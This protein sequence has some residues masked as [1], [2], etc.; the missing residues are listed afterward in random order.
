MAERFHRCG[1]C[2]DVDKRFCEHR[3]VLLIYIDS[4]PLLVR[5]STEESARETADRVRMQWRGEPF[6]RRES[7]QHAEHGVAS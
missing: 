2:R 4:V 3:G 1:E 6:H 7:A 5:G